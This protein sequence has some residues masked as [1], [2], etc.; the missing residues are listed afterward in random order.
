[1]VTESGMRQALI[2][3]EDREVIDQEDR[4]DAAEGGKEGCCT[5]CWSCLRDCFSSSSQE[6]FHVQLYVASPL[7]LGLE[8]PM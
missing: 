6:S 3:Q 4:E 8:S 2:D 5:K 7:G 1:M